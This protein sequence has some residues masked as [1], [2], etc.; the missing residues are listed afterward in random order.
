MKLEELNEYIFFEIKVSITFNKYFDNIL[1]QK[2]V[3]VHWNILQF[4]FN[5]LTTMRTFTSC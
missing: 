2:Y 3:N 5:I 1:E 4:I